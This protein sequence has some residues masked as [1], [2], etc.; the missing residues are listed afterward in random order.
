MLEMVPATDAHESGNVSRADRLVPP[1][2]AS[3]YVRQGERLGD[4]LVVVSAILGR[5]IG[6]LRESAGLKSRAGA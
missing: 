1:E 4:A 3:H 5:L 6:R 2:H